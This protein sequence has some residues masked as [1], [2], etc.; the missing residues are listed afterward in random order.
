MVLEDERRKLLESEPLFEFCNGFQD[1][2]EDVAIKAFGARESNIM[3]VLPSNTDRIQDACF[4]HFLSGMR[5]I[6][7]LIGTDIN[8]D[9]VAAM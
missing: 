6:S 3:I 1:V 2:E 9:A 8:G 4:H 5:F 7:S